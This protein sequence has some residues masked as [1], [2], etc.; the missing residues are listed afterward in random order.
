VICEAYHCESQTGMQTAVRET[1]LAAVCATMKETEG[2][3]NA[4]TERAREKKKRK[5]E[6][7][8]QPAASKRETRQRGQA[9]RPTRQWKKKNVKW[10]CVKTGTVIARAQSTAGRLDCHSQPLR[11][12]PGAEKLELITFMYIARLAR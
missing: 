11:G 8:H 7:R 1:A 3:R 4:S 10:A 12:M 9:F 6:C 5:E 2:K